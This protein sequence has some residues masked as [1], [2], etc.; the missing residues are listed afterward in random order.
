[1]VNTDHRR[2]VMGTLDRSAPLINGEEMDSMAETPHPEWRSEAELVQDERAWS[3]LHWP[4]ARPAPRLEPV[5]VA[6][7]H[8]RHFGVRDQAAPPREREAWE[9]LWP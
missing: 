9:L 2:S 6:E 7:L 3:P 1:M 4:T 8:G 5:S